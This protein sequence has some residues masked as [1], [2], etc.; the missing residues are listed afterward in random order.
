MNDIPKVALVTGAAHRIGAQLARTLH[1]A[2]FNI[3]AHYGHSKAAATALVNELNEARAESATAIQANLTNLQDVAILAERA[4]ASWGHIDALVNNASR[5]YPTDVS[6]VTPEIWAD[7][8][9]ANVRGPF[10]L[11]QALAPVLA[12]RKGCIINIVDIYAE[13]PLKGYSVYSISKAGIAMLT[14]SLATE[15]GPDV[16]VNG[17]SP[18]AILWPED[19]AALNDSAKQGIIKKTA[20]GR[21]GSPADIAETARF[22][23]E[24]A[25]YVTG[26]IIAVDG[27]RSLNQ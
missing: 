24:D 22:L 15:L 23:I 17:I 11:S 14:K 13:R 3:V 21:E 27:G 12:K 26:Q 6:K 20:L 7:L 19:A 8:M 5:F 18:G 2:G 1:Q 9:Q 10:F 25:P 4:I 16:R